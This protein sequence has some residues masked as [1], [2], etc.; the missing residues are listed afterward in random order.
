MRYLLL[1]FILA[2]VA[3]S[4]SQPTSEKTESATKAQPTTEANTTVEAPATGGNLLTK[5]IF[6][7]VLV[8]TL[9]SEEET[10]WR[11]TNFE[12]ETRYNYINSLFLAIREGKLSAYSHPLGVPTKADEYKVTPDK[13]TD[14]LKDTLTFTV[15]NPDNGKLEEYTQ[16][17]EYSP[18]DVTLMD[19]VE[20]WSFDP[21]TLRPQK[22]VRGVALTFPVFSM[23]GEYKGNRRLFY[24]WFDDQPLLDYP[25]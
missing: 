8:K 14:L 17:T 2:F 7:D 4:D 19:F 1:V 25:A 3:C 9:P 24:V 21:E 16:V 13:F 6:Y 15:E 22:L 5:Q 12:E 11:L 23:Q 20:E 10:D 18:T